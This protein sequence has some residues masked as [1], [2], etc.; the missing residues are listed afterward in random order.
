MSNLEQRISA[1][2]QKIQAIDTEREI[3]FQELTQLKQQQQNFAQPIIDATVTQ[4]SS[5]KDKVSLFRSLF[6]GREDV[7]PKRWE[8]SKTGKSGY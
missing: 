6:K 2:A 4:Q 5:S 1:L 3:L 7:Y 8:N